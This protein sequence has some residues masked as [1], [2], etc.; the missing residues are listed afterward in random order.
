MVFLLSRIAVKINKMPKYGD[1][2]KISTYESGKKKALFLRDVEF[3]SGGE[4]VINHKSGWVLASP[5]TRKIHRPNFYTFNNKIYEN[6]S[7]YNPE[8]DKIALTNPKLVAEKKISYSHLD[9]NGHVYNAFYAD[10]MT[11]VL[12]QNFYNKTV[13][14]F[15]INYINEMFK[16][17]RLQ[18]FLSVE[19]DKEVVI[20]G[21]NDEKECFLS[22][23]IYI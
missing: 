12:E 22:K 19:S 9:A 3:S 15:R 17:D 11:D 23:I 21:K 8:F 20:L 16:G 13:S 14:E 1:E 10:F 18:L 4:V 7:N 6:R 2:I 5:T